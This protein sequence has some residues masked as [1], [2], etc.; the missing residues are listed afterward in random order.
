VRIQGAAQVIEFVDGFLNEVGLADNA[1]ATM[2]EWPFRYFVQL[3]R[4]RSKPHSGA[5]EVDGTREG[6]VDHGNEMVPFRNS[7]TA[8]RSAT[9]M[10][11][12]MVST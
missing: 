11:G 2:S 7:T 4:D 8:L 3:W 5:P 9:W 6:V 12:V 1:P 10:S